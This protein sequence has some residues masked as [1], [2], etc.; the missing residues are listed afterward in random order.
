MGEIWKWTVNLFENWMDIS[1]GT[2]QGWQADTNCQD[3]KLN[4]QS[5]MWLLSYL[6]NSC[7]TELY[8]C[9][10]DEFKSLS[11]FEQGGA[12]FLYLIMSWMFQMMTDVV[13]ALKSVI[14]QFRRKQRSRVRMLVW[15]SSN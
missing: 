9:I 12:T 8:N 13:T 11:T 1:F 7:T 5:S 14:S 6:M 2:V 15:R 4:R 10:K 3:G